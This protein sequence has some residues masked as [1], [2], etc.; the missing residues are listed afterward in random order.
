MEHRQAFRAWRKRCRLSPSS[1]AHWYVAKLI[2]EISVEDDRLKVIHRT[3]TVIYANSEQEAYEKAMSLGREREITYR[4]PLDKLV[5]TT[6][7]GLGELNV[8]QED[9]DHGADFFREE[10]MVRQEQPKPGPSQ[11]WAAK[12]GRNPVFQPVEPA[13]HHR[14]VKLFWE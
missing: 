9:P 14:E 6:F 5:R 2:E 8:I 11:H 12:P 10:P 1:H 13:R 3:V 7:W 4:N